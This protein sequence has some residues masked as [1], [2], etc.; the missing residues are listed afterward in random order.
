MLKY[1]KLIFFLEYHII[2]MT[3]YILKV[4]SGK[5]IKAGI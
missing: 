4:L 2:L 1:N 5:N 3:L